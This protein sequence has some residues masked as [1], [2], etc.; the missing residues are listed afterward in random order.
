MRK[1][2]VLIHRYAGLAMTVFLILVGVTGLA[3]YHELDRWLNPALL[4]VPVRDA[5]MLDAFTLRERAEILEPRSRVDGVGLHREPQAKTDPATGEPY[6]LPYNELY[7]DPSPGRRSGRGSGGRYLWRKRISSRFYRL[8][9]TLAL[10]ESTGNLGGY[11]LGITALLWTLDCFV[12][13]Y[14]TLPPSRGRSN[15]SLSLRMY[16]QCSLDAA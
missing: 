11:V 10:P 3:F 5:P 7:L 13:F 15:G 6:A 1:L 16:S 12:G 8:H 9:Y 2:F 4:T 14:L